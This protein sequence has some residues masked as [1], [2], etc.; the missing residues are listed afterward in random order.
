LAARET[1]TGRLTDFE[2]KMGLD[3]P[4]PAESTK[5]YC[6][7]SSEVESSRGEEEGTPQKQLKM[8]H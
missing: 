4:H 5:Q 8:G 3:W 1:T 7:A 6:L 2:K